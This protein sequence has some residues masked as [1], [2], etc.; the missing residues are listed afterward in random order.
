MEYLHAKL[1]CHRDLNPQSVLFSR[2]DGSLQP[3][4]K[5]ANFAF[6][7]VSKT[8]LLLYKIVKSKGWLLPDIYDQ[9]IFTPQMDIF[10]LGLL[11]AYVLSGGLH[12]FGSDKEERVFSIKKRKPMSLTVDQLKD[13]LRAA[14]VFDLIRSMVTYNPDERPTANSVLNHT[15][16][17]QS[18]D[19][20][21][22]A[23]IPL[24]PNGKIY[25]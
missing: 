4:I 9:T 5:L 19:N 25:I 6:I 21:P 11:F 7:R 18:T 1:I 16:F 13:V 10:A 15:F 2:S 3:R 8:A 17:G 14:E 23:S 12:A 20:E 22:F 24:N